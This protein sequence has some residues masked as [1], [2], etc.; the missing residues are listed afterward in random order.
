MDGTAFHSRKNE[1]KQNN[2]TLEALLIGN[3]ASW[4]KQNADRKTTIMTNPSS[5]LR[6]LPETM[7]A[8]LLTGVGGPEMLSYATNVPVPRPNPDELLIQVGAAGMNNTDINVRIGWYDASVHTSTTDAAATAAAAAAVIQDGGASAAAAGAAAAPTKGFWKG[9]GI[10]AHYPRIQG[11]DVAGRVVAVGSNIVDE[12]QKWLGRR[13]LVN[14]CCLVT[15]RPEK[16]DGDDEDVDNHN[17]DTVDDIEYLGSERDGGFAQFCTVP[18]RS[19][20][21][22]RDDC[23]LTD[24]ELASLPCSYSTAENLLTRAHC[25]KHDIV[26]VTGA[27]GGVGS[28]VVQLAAHVRGATVYAVAS[29][30]QAGSILQELGATKVLDRQEDL[31]AALGRESVTLVVDVVG[32]S[33]WPALLDV[34]KRH[35]R[36]AVAGAVAGPMVD[37]DLRTLYLKDLTLYGCTSLADGVFDHLV[38]LINDGRVKPVLAQS[39]PLAEIHTAQQVFLQKQYVGKLVLLPPPL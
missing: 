28:A 39:F 22:I 35:G 23:Q 2:S 5:P 12:Q 7:H 29:S 36:L 15:P 38:T 19:V 9:D 33:A 27:S 34:L 8:V 11:A 17:D 13:V 16:S 24:A 20:H 37:L 25:T 26:L 14:P 21:L 6:S 10:A 30:K 31:V 4:R 18:A 32:G 3:Q 1:T